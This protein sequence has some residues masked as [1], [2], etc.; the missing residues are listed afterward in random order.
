[1]IF[2]KL[3]KYEEGVE[4][5]KNFKDENQNCLITYFNQHCFNVYSSDQNYKYLIDNYFHTYIDGFGIYL[6]VKLFK[7]NKFQKFNSSDL[8][9][10]ILKYFIINNFNIFIIGGNF[11]SDIIKNTEN[12]GL[13]ICGY[14]NGFFDQAGQR[15]IIKRIKKINPD[16]ILIGMGVPKQ[17]YF[18]AE[19]STELKGKLIICV[20]NFFEFY[21]G[22][23]KRIPKSF[24]N[25]GI[26]WIFRLF[27]EPRRLWKRYLIGIPVFVFLLFKG[28]FNK[29]HY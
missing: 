4:I 27:T 18:A 28:L 10:K 16:A 25:L 13:K 26:E 23:I 22:T 5:L 17:E 7:Y 2:D 20:G 11:S 8:N 9:E 3:I 19:L 1:M 29:T 6:A 21:F 15:L 24:R 12:K 14:Q